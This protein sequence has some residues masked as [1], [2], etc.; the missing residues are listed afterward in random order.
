MNPTQTFNITNTYKGHICM[1]AL[2]T[3]FC[4]IQG[5]CIF[6]SK[7]IQRVNQGRKS[8][9]VV[10]LCHEEATGFDPVWTCMPV[11]VHMR[12]LMYEKYNVCMRKI[13]QR[14]S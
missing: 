13:A 9:A 4:R 6:S 1:N 8:A 3:V 11:I 5:K 2:S 14:Y 7:K 10:A 12:N